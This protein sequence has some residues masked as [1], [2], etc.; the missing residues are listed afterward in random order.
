VPAHGVESSAITCRGLGQ[1]LYKMRSG[2]CS[3]LYH[4]EV[5]SHSKPKVVPYTELRKIVT[6]LESKF[7]Q[8]RSPRTP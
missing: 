1:S 4:R 7:N 2:S 6:A 3:N 5:A 8:M